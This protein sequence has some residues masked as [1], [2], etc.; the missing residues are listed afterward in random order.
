MIELKKYVWIIAICVLIVAGFLIFM[1]SDSSVEDIVDTVKESSIVSSVDDELEACQDD[2]CFLKLAALRDD[3]RVCSWISNGFLRDSCVN[4]DWKE[5]GCMF[6]GLIGEGD[7]CWLSRAKEQNNPQF[8]ESLR[9]GVVDCLYDLAVKNSDPSFCRGYGACLDQFVDEF[10]DPEACRLQADSDGCFDDLASEIGDASLCSEGTFYCEIKM[11]DDSDEQLEYAKK[12]D[13]QYEKTEFSVT[14][15][16]SPDDLFSGYV[17][18]DD[19]SMMILGGALETSN[20]EICFLLDDVVYSIPEVG[21][22]SIQ[23]ACVTK[24]AFE[25]G[26][27]SVCSKIKL[28]SERVICDDLV[29]NDCEGKYKAVCA[30]LS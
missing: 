20:A 12:V 26:S 13:A 10:K 15:A 21:T 14:K 22:V 27:A 29:N 3:T 6:E 18:L 2:I 9:S 8:C 16:N 11:I 24:V 25:S 7:E 4:S 17:G 28:E 30:L 1:F 23:N 19:R 5:D